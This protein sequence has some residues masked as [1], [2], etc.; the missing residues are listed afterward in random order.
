MFKSS[1]KLKHIDMGSTL[2]KRLKQS[3]FN[4]PAQEAIL[5]I[6]VASN[7][8]KSK[9]EAVCLKY[10]ITQAQ[11]NALR[12][13]NGK[14]PDGYPRCE[15]ITRMIDP[16]SDVTRLIDRLIKVGLVER[17]ASRE[18]KRLSLSRITDKGREILKKVKPEIDSLSG[19]ISDNLNK[20]ESRQLSFLL[21]KIYKDMF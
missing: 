20:A 3:K 16:A 1:Y 5:N 15:I 13:L 2:K 7:H 11:F 17:F 19:L 8:L 18:D 14:Y 12:I 10:G 6:F 9:V 4:S 21:E